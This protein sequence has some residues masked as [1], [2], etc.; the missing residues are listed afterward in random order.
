[1]T[2]DPRHPTILASLGIDQLNP[3]QAAAL[4]A[5]TADTD[6][7]LVSPTGSG[8]T[9]AFLLPLVA[10]LRPGV[11]TVQALVLSPSREL[12]LQIE[13]VWKK[14]A[15][16]FKVTVCYGGH[17][18]ETEQNSLTNPP[19]LLI[20]TPGRICDH[21]TRRSVALDGVQTLVLDEFDKSLTLGFH[22]EM[23]FIVERL[24]G[25]RQ[26]VLVSATSGIRIPDFVGLRHPQKLL[27]APDEETR[28]DLTMAVVYS[29]DKDKIDT[30]FALLCSL[31]SEPALIFCNHRDAAERTG[32]LLAD[33]G[34][35]NRVYHGGLE[36]DQRERA[37]IQFRNGSVR[38]LVTT[39]LA[40]RGLDIPD[41]KYVIHYHLPL[42]AHEF[43]HRNGRTARMH[44]S[45]TAYVLLH[46]DEPRPDFLPDNLAE[47][48]VPTPAGL[49][50]PPAFQTIYVSGGRKNKLSKG[51]I[52]GFFCQKGGLD[53]ADLGLI[54]VK[55]SSSYV[56]V[57]TERVEALL[58]ALRPEKM[59]GKK[60][61]IEA[62]R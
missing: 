46:A 47:V 49:P 58:A 50:L 12:A 59:K 40:A 5:I 1:M 13:Q 4:A 16:G 54:E 11:N 19:A 27:F 8:K 51:D 44:A 9:L 56:A 30:L 48:A 2:T 20:G 45:G 52:V 60:Y 62:A 61:K 26:R 7:V 18:V 33:R 34:I 38:Y 29:P 24:T 42:Q 55:D 6:T 36:Q 39:D 57:R 14:M 21:I 53:K 22:D 41:M 32:Q 37:L 23:A 28:P 43:T 35:P 3:M 15:T 31:E 10:L 17:S 25:L